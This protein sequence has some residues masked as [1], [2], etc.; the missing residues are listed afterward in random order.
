V[1]AIEHAFDVP[2]SLPFQN[3]ANLAFSSASELGRVGHQGA[4]LRSAGIRLHRTRHPQ[5]AS[6]PRNGA[7]SANALRTA[8]RSG[9]TR[10]LR[11]LASRI[12]RNRLQVTN[13][14]MTGTPR[15]PWKRGL[16][17]KVT[18]LRVP[19]KPLT[20][21]DGESRDGGRLPLSSRSRGGR[22]DRHEWQRDRC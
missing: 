22:W 6:P 18:V 17:A 21:P 4:V 20:R 11:R 13:V 12:A 7:V 8:H 19:I 2:H 16:A 9:Q 15:L 14:V 5:S 1:L 10:S 3:L